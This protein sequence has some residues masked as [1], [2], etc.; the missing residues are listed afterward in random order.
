MRG[1]SRSLVLLALF[2]IPQN[3]IGEQ[4]DEELR[5]LRGYVDFD[6]WTGLRPA[7]TTVEIYIKDPILSLV[8]RLTRDEDPDLSDLLSSLKLIRVQTYPLDA[9]DTREIK[10]RVD[11]I[12]KKLEKDKWEIVVR[13]REPDQQ[14]H[15]YIKSSKDEVNGLVIMAAKYGENISFVNIVGDIDLNSISRL[16]NKFDIP[17]LDSLNTSVPSQQGGTP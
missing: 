5:K 6:S 10:A 15:V 2:L 16:G 14:V 8:A 9:S 4:E 1:I 11:E 13:A 12:R 7:E 3:A 17:G